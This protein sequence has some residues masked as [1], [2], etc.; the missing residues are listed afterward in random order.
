ML[1]LQFK[2]VATSCT[3]RVCLRGE[4][5]NSARVSTQIRGG[6][7]P[8]GNV[9]A[10]RLH[11]GGDAFLSGFALLLQ[12]NLLPGASPPGEKSPTRQ[13]QMRIHGGARAERLLH[14]RLR[15]RAESGRWNCRVYPGDP[16]RPARAGCCRIAPYPGIAVLPILCND[17]TDSPSSKPAKLTKRTILK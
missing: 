17:S 13:R 15:C 6:C 1:G 14:A 8:A 11:I 4:I 9:V 7:G 10:G 5:F 12:H 3:S 2:R 16:D